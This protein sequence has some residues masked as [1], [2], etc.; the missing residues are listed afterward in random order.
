ML[1]GATP[2]FALSSLGAHLIWF[3]RFFLHCTCIPFQGYEAVNYLSSSNGYQRSNNKVATIQREINGC[4]AS[5][6]QFQVPTSDSVPQA[7]LALLPVDPL[8]SSGSQP[9][10]VSPVS[11]VPQSGFAGNEGMSDEATERTSTNPKP[12]PNARVD[13]SLVGT[14]FAP[15]QQQDTTEGYQRSA[16]PQLPSS[17]LGNVLNQAMS[18]GPL[19]SFP[20]PSSST[21][22]SGG[23]VQGVETL[24]NPQ[25]QVAFSCLSFLVFS[26]SLLNFPTCTLIRHEASWSIQLCLA[27]IKVLTRGPATVARSLSSSLGSNKLP[28]STHKPQQRLAQRVALRRASLQKATSAQRCLS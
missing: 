14:L 16:L 23:S 9:V 19:G 26:C 28:G 17:P 20:L 18:S 15:R 8:F 21:G 27:K 6:L 2:F 12:I 1:L 22:S 10:S 11:A 13:S 7:K 4:P 25:Q 5:L 24:L 3:I